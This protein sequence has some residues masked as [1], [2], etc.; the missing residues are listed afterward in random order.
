[1]NL[2]SRP[3]IA[4]RIQVKVEDQENVPATPRHARSRTVPSSGS[5]EM[6]GPAILHYVFPQ[7]SAPYADGRR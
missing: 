3:A 1:M 2:L 6:T 4:A 5:L 7:I